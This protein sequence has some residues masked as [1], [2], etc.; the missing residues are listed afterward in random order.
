MNNTDIDFKAYNYVIGGK[1]IVGKVQFTDYDFM[2]IPHQEMRTLVKKRM[3]AQLAEFMLEN[4]L[5]EFTQFDDPVA[6]K[7]TVVAR[8]YLA[9]DDQVKILRVVNKI[10]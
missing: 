4:R 3:A 10:V 2:G 6:G 1:L 9:P 8:A 7:K 5:L